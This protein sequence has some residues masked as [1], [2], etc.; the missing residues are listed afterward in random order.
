MNAYESMTKGRIEALQ[1]EPS[2]ELR[3]RVFSSVKEKTSAAAFYRK[4]RLRTLL[5]AAALAALSVTAVFAYSG[6]LREFM[7]GDS[8]AR[9]VEAARADGFVNRNIFE[10]FE[11]KN[12]DYSHTSIKQISF[13]ALDELRQEAAFDVKE[14]RLLP[15]GSELLQI[16]GV[17]Y[18]ESGYMY[19]A[20]FRYFS[21]FVNGRRYDPL[22]SLILTQL[23]IGPGAYVEFDVVHPI[24]KVT[25]GDAEASVVIQNDSGFLHIYWIQNGVLYGLAGSGL[26]LGALITIADSVG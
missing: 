24:E 6:V 3:N 15:E 8:T 11:L 1:A 4:P 16:F 9:Q 25:V 22:N 7:F 19:G 10:H 26:D 12:S 14:P 13:S 23:Y 20:V 18:T 5:V 17:Q 21:E 2:P